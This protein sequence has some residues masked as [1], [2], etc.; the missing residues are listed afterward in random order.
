M[1]AL[2]Q[3]NQWKIVTIVQLVIFLITFGAFI[4]ITVFQYR[5]HGG[6]R[7]VL[8]FCIGITIFHTFKIVGAILG[9]VLINQDEINTS[10]FIP[11]YIFDT[12]SL[13]IITNAIKSLVQVML[14]DQQKQNMPPPSYTQKDIE[15]G[16][17]N[18]SSNKKEK[19]NFRPFRILSVVLLAAIVLNIIGVSQLSGGDVTSTTEALTKASSVLFLVGVLLLIGTLVFVHAS[20]DDFNLVAKILIAALVI[21]IVR[22]SYTMAS[23]FNGLDF[24]HPNQFMIYFGHFQYY[25]FMGMLME[26]IAICIVLGAFSVW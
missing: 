4:T 20:G 11:T 24:E 15:I 9:L 6:L 19:V 8:M 23:A 1:L 17:Y 22:C 18:T 7:R 2:P 13:A 25:C 10:L 16:Q 21:L 12:I 26:L 14:L 3:F 5:K